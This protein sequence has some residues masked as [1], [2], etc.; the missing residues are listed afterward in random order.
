MEKL[1]KE[2]GQGPHLEMTQIWLLFLKSN[3]KILMKH[4]RIVVRSRKCKKSS[5]E[6]RRIKF[7]LLFLIL[8]ITPSLQQDRYS[9]TNSMKLERLLEIRQDW[10]LKDTIS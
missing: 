10:L 5:N 3:P 6:L 4:C 1:L 8:K 7:K 9:V 2:L